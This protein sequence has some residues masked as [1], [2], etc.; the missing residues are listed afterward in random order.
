[1]SHDSTKFWNKD[2]EQS[3][4]IKLLFLSKLLLLLLLLS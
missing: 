2:L 4:G 3:S 1:M